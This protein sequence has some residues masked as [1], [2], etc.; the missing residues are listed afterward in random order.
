M[1][2]E[3]VMYG[4]NVPIEFEQMIGGHV[5]AHPCAA[6]TLKVADRELRKAREHAETSDKAKPAVG[7]VL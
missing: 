1:G 7:T 5:Q 3:K 4:R 6:A 2:A